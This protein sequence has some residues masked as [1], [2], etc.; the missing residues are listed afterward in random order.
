MISAALDVGS[1]TARML[2]AQ[3]DG[4]ILTDPHYY[5]RVT[6]L[7]G[8]FHPET[9]LAPASMERS[10]CALEHFAAI[11]NGFPVEKI[12]VVGT[13][14]LRNAVNSG[15]FLEA[16][17]RRTNLDLR[18][19]DGATEAALSCQGILSVL[20]P[21]PARAILFDIGGGSTEIIL[22]QEGRICLQK[23]L[24]LGA[25]RLFEDYPATDHYDKVIRQGLEPLLTNPVWINW[26][27]DRSPIELIGTAGTV[28]TLAALKLQMT[29]YAGER[30]NN[31]IL[32]RSWLEDIHTGLLNLS[33][34]QRL[35]L[36]GMEEGRAD[37]IIPGLQ[38]VHVL[39]D[40]AQGCSL[41]VAD[42][43]LLEGL[44][45]K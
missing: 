13:A 43:G 39:L 45:L 16:L 1:N 4:N 21:L 3:I 26:Q 20:K 36:P 34:E 25:V 2:I 19:I 14:A 12:A 22:W 11:L 35:R 10:L 29:E 9:G 30:V 33:I 44:L 18:I 40:L 23:S 38:I 27:Q 6:R 17:K 8:D 24:P 5:R 28:T 41:R 31:L 37:I 32:T 15:F 7:A 42:A